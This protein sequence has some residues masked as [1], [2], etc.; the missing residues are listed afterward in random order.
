MTFTIPKAKITAGISSKA[1]K[2][3]SL[4]PLPP[5]PLKLIA[6]SVGICPKLPFN[7]LKSKARK[8]PSD[9]EK[10]PENNKIANTKTT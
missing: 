9:E 5:A 10:I 2:K 7:T 1:N 4:A 8:T 6:L 3:P